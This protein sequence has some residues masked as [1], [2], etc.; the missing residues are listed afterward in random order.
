MLKY[1][2]EQKKDIKQRLGLPFDK[3]IILYAPTFREYDR[4]KLNSC[5]IKPP[6]SV[7]KWKSSLSDGYAFLL[8]AHYEVVNVLGIQEDGFVYDVSKYH[9][10]NDLIAI[11]DM[12]ISDYSSIYFD[13]AIT[14][15]PML[16]FS[17][18]IEA[19]E[20]LRGL[21]LD[22]EED[23]LCKLNLTEDTLIEEIKSMNFEEYSARTKIFK[24]RFAPNSGKACEKVIE[25][26]KTLV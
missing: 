16:N 9:C 7:E 3:K 21:Y 18:D 1:T 12:L 2:E 19:Y 11:S 20:K 6:I 10:L 24:N 15:K 17:Y 22:I 13:Y 5:Y 4:D 25:K 26:L 8:R 23:L 14:E